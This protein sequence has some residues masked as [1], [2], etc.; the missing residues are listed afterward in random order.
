[1]RVSSAFNPKRMHPVLH[2]EKGHFGVDY[3]APEGTPVWAAADG[4]IV[5]RGPAGGAGNLVI[6]SHD[7]GMQT[8]YMHLSKFAKNQ[9]VGDRV[10]QKTVIGYVGTT[11]LSTGPHLHFGLKRGRKFVDPATVKSISRPGIPTK[12]RA[13]FKEETSDVLGKLDAMAGVE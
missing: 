2:R 3:A 5:H 7:A 6:L 10:K 11:G 12:Q 1:M 9:K 4:T 8:L 13:K